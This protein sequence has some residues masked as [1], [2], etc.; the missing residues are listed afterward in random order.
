MISAVYT[1]TVRHRR[2]EPRVRVL[3]HSVTYFFLDLEEI[4]RLFRFP[5]LFAYD[6]PALFSFVR[7]HFIGGRKE[8]VKSIADTVRERVREKHGFTP[9]GPIRLLAQISY[10]GFC[11]NPVVFYYCYDRTGERLEAIVAEITNTPWNETH[12]YVLRC[13]PS[14][15]ARQKFEFEKTFHVSPFLSMDY[16][17]AWTFTKPTNSLV[18]HME[19]H[20]NARNPG[21]KSVHFDATL[22]LH[23]HEWSF[24]AVAG[25][26]FR[27]P[28]MTLKTLS[29]IYIHAGILWM[30]RFTFYPHPKFA[31]QEKEP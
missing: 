23:R 16:G 24:R 18:V 11:F 27:Q 30:R 2:F 12:A 31:A 14:E 4:P 8:P 22:T 17:Y 25:A 29:L 21:A 10:F 1:G 7:K 15:N 20:P 9:E 5:F 26:L 19:N 3:A 28:F 6:R 13:S